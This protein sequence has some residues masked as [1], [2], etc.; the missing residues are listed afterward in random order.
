MSSAPVPALSVCVLAYN[1]AKLLPDVVQSILAQQ[2]GDFELLLSD[3]CSSDDTWACIQQLAAS[4]PRVRPLRTPRNLGMAAHA[5][6]A[7]QHCRADLIALL[8]HDDI[9]EPS[10]LGEWFAVAQKYPDVAFVSNGYRKYHTREVQ[11]EALPEWNDGPELMRKRLLPLF[12]S[13]FRGT[14]LIRRTCWDAVGGMREQFG[15]LADVDLWMR[16]AAR[17]P[18]GYVAK[19]LIVVRHERPEDYPSAYKGWSWSRL[20]LGHEIYGQNHR[21]FYGRDSL[22]ARTLLLW[23]RVRVSYSVSYWLAYA[24]YKRRWEM[25]ANSQDVASEYE[26]LPEKLVRQAL[27]RCAQLAIS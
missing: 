21:E 16:L 24:I 4:D 2:F 6:F 1:H 27:A 14:A 9:C 15:M 5:N 7:F 17:W 25:L 22:R 19:P 12:G 10:L 23:Y 3:D 20:R 13:P 26:L 8:H 18:V 11:C